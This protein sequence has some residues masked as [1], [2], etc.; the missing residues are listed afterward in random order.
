MGIGMPISQSN[1]ERIR[2]APVIVFGGN[3]FGKPLVPLPS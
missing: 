1:I 3:E 2:F